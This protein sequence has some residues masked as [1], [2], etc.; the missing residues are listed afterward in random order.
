VKF[1]SNKQL[2]K[3]FRI[4]AKSVKVGTKIKH[5]LFGGGSYEGVVKSIEKCKD[6]EKYGTMVSS[7][8]MEKRSRNYVLDLDNGHWCYGNQVLSI[9]STTN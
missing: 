9:V 1:S 8:P 6:G 5:T 4:M 2:K 7:M 3:R